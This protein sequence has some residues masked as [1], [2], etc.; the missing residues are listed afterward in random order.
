MNVISLYPESFASNCYLMIS[1]GHAF[2]VDPS[3]SSDAIQNALLREN[4]ML[5]GILLTHGHFDHML[6][7]DLLRQH[8]G[9]QAYIH[10]DDAYRLTDG[11]ANAF[12]TFFGKERVWA[13]AEH[14]LSHNQCL[15]LGKEEIRVLHTP[16]HTEGCCC[17]LCDGKLITG[18]TVF[19]ESY[20]RCDLPGGSLAQ[21]RESFSYL[22]TLPRDLVIY[23]GHG[24]TSRLG[25]A[26]DM[27]AY[28]L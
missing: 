20:G 15:R 27:C 26:L 11:R 25:D 3:I 7:L 8:T 12:Y 18:D 4:A 21:L 16:G 10:E 2:A 24:S 23:P 9:A 14:T 1:E 22:R 19:A 5:D 28:L 17:F 6:S 13:P